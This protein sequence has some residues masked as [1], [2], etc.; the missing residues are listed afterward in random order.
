MI[1]QTILGFIHPYGLMIGIGIVI[2][3]IVLFK[4]S[5]WLSVNEKFVDFVF[6]DLLIS[7]A[8]G[9]GCAAVFQALYDFIE[10]P[11]G[12]F[13][14]SGSITFMG[15]LLG[16]TAVFLLVYLVFRKRYTARLSDVLTVIPCSILIAHAFGRVG[17]FLVGCCYGKH[18][19]SFLGVVFPYVYCNEHSGWKCAVHPTQL[20]EAIFLFLLFVICTLLIYKKKYIHNMSLY[21]FAYGIFRFLNEFLRGDHRGEFLSFISPSQFWSVAMVLLAVAV[22]FFE[23][24]YIRVNNSYSDFTNKERSEFALDNQEDSDSDSNKENK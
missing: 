1:P 15:G 11:S 10:N 14:I 23:K 7:T 20:Y 19:D 18:T 12:G 2:A 17:C 16:G 24:K 8:L 13:H 21:L 9:F 22:F 6:Y 5:K 3:F 4:Y